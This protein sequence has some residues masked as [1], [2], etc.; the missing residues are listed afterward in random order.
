MRNSEDVT[1]GTS[2]LDRAA[3]LR[4]DTARLKAALAAGAPVLPMWRGKVLVAGTPDGGDLSLAF[5][6][7][8]DPV[9]AKSDAEPVMLGLSTDGEQPIFALDISAW[10]P[11]TVDEEAMNTFFDPSVQIHPAERMS[12]AAFRECVDLVA[13]GIAQGQCQTEAPVYRHQ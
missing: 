1:F 2:G 10:T 9:L 13:D 11:K 5:R 8:S 4:G 6:K 3:A 7:M 12:G